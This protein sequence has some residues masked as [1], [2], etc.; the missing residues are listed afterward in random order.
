APRDKCG[1]PASGPFV[2][3]LA[4]SRHYYSEGDLHFFAICYIHVQRRQ[5]RTTFPQ[6]K[7]VRSPFHYTRP[8]YYMDHIGSNLYF[9]RNLMVSQGGTRPVA[10]TTPGFRYRC[11]C[12]CLS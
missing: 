4:D 6:N 2:F 10:N 8:T 1:I 3:H 7:R 5:R 12:R 9:N 11:P